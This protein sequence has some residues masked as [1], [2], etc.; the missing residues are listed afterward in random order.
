MIRI[1]L[2]GFGRVGRAF[3][4]IVLSAPDLE[5]AVVNELDPD[6][7]NLAYLLKYDSTYGRL[8]TPVQVL[9]TRELLVGNRPPVRFYSSEDPGGVPWDKHGIDILVDATGVSRNVKKDR[10]LIGRHARKVVVTHSHDDVDATVIF[11]VNET[12]YDPAVHHLISSSICDANAL[13][14]V[15]FEVHRSWGIEHCFVTTL[16]PWLSYQNLL[17]GPV[18]SVSSPGHFWKDYSLGRGS[19]GSLIAKD[20]TAGAATLKVL[21]ELVGK[22]DAISFRVPTSIVSACDVT[23]ILRKR[24]SAAEAN[25]QF[26]A[27]AGRRP[28][29]LGFEEDHLVSI[30]YA[31]TT[32]SG[33]VDGLRT[34]VLNGTMLKLVIWYDNEWGYSS[35]VADTVRL[36]ARSRPG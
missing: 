9:P 18:S 16:H 35:R 7:T 6:L 4:R 11:G 27:V 12:A 22:L 26:R 21:P 2:N 20:T 14:P 15:L 10:D 32:Q 5:L 25:D 23:A 33:I 13:A 3:T 1:G 24:V 36:L 28:D 31:G 34:K 17:D 29:L 8:D 30:D 19:T